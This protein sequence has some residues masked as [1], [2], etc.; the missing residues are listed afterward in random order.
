MSDRSY[1]QQKKAMSDRSL[2]K[3]EIIK[4]ESDLQD[5]MEKMVRDNQEGLVLKD[6]LGVYSPNKRHWLKLKRDYL[7]DGGLADAVD[8]IVLGAYKGTGRHGGLYSTYLM[9]CLDNK[10]NIFKTVCKAHNGLSDDQIE[11]YTK[12]LSMIEYNQQNKPSW[13]DVTRSIEPSKKI[14]NI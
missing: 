2:S 4:T 7:D 1:H 6:S 10:N 13:L 9:G 11:Y 8:L 14:T 3:L 12:N 5:L